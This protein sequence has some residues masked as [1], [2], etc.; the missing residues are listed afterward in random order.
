MQIEYEA[1]FTN[2]NKAVGKLYQMKYQISPDE[3]N[4]FEKLVFDMENP[5]R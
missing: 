1:T 2:I 5:F 3:I 4:K